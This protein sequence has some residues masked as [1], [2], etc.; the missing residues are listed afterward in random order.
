[1]VVGTIMKS[2]CANHIQSDALKEKNERIKL[3]V[4]K[5]FKLLDF[6]RIY[7]IFFN[8]DTYF[9]EILWVNCSYVMCNSGEH[10]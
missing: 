5:T 6:S 2:F 7:R 10:E 9:E 4:N 8:E 3:H 1:M